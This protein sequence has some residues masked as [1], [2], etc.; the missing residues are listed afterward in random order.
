MASHSQNCTE[1]PGATKESGM[2]Q[3]ARRG[4]HESTSV[5]MSSGASSCRAG[6]SRQE[7]IERPGYRAAKEGAKQP[8]E[9]RAT[10][11]TLDGHEGAEYGGDGAE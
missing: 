8:G 9:F 6:T 4:F 11:R 1:Q 5:R 2:C 7:G 10:R 3:L